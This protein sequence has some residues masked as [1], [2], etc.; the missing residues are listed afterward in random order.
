MHTHI[1]TFRKVLQCYPLLNCNPEPFAT[2][3]GWGRGSSIFQ[4]SI[5]Y[6]IP[7]VAKWLT[8]NCNHHLYV[9]YL[10]SLKNLVK[11]LSNP[12]IL[13]HVGELF[14]WSLWKPCT[15]CTNITETLMPTNKSFINWV[16]TI[17]FPANFLQQ[18]KE[19]ITKE[20]SN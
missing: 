16:W 9:L 7:L 10:P 6:F 19:I 4:L 17:W 8:L 2:L 13:C 11:I 12:H 3:R 5:K 18:R 1:H 15:F 14:K 20:K